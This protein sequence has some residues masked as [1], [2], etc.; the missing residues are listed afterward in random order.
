MGETLRDLPAVLLLSPFLAHI[1]SMQ[2]TVRMQKSG[3]AEGPEPHLFFLVQ[4]TPLW[5]VLGGSAPSPAIPV[6]GSG[7]APFRHFFLARCR[8]RVPRGQNKGFP[9]SGRMQG[10][11][12]PARCG[13]GPPDGPFEWPHSQFGRG[14]YLNSD[15]PAG[16]GS[17]RPFGADL[18]GA[19]GLAPEGPP[20]PRAAWAG[21]GG[22]IGALSAA[23]APLDRPKPGSSPKPQGHGTT[24]RLGTRG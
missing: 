18:V 22:C 16:C 1:F 9:R 17:K 14:R 2:G 24:S 8:A 4:C 6:A 3:L 7:L 12:E 13:S 20:M 21:S 15:P 23:Q 11:M 5:V 19:R 10:S